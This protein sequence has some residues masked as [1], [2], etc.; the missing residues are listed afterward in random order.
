MRASLA[1]TKEHVEHALAPVRYVTLDEAHAVP[2]GRVRQVSAYVEEHWNPVYRRVES[3]DLVQILLASQE[4]VG[5][6]VTQRESEQS[7]L[8]RRAQQNAEEFVEVLQSMQVQASDAFY[9]GVYETIPGNDPIVL[10]G[11]I[12]RGEATYEWDADGNRGKMTHDGI[13]RGTMITGG[14]AE[15]RSRTKG[16][17]FWD[18]GFIEERKRQIAAENLR[19][20]QNVRRALEACK[21]E[22]P[23]YR[24]VGINFRK[25]RRAV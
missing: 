8:A 14:R 22:L 18:K 10:D 3:T 2:E 24:N 15:H 17:V 12:L 9:N 25:D 11:E 6:T 19:P 1:V 21:G 13:V 5:W 7:R 16:M 4:Q 23:M 20:I